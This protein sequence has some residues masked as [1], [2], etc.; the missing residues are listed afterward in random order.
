MRVSDAVVDDDFK[1]E[2]LVMDEFSILL[3][4]TY[5]FDRDSVCLEPLN[6]CPEFAISSLCRKSL[7]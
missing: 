6:R 3:H 4:H 5:P 2:Q 1:H 7:D